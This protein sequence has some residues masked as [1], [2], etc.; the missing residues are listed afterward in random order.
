ML[1]TIDIGNT[2]IVMGLFDGKELINSW[3]LRTIQ[4]RTVDEFEVLLSQRWSVSG[5][6]ASQINEI[7]I[8][9]VVPPILKSLTTALKRMCHIE[10]LIVGPGVKTGISILLDNPKEVGA[11]RVVN[12]VAAHNRFKSGIIVV[13]FGTATTFDCISPKAEYLGGAIAPGI[14]ISTQALIKN[15]AQLPDVEI[16]KP[17]SVV[18]KNTVDGLKSGFF[19]G[20]I[21]LVDGL[22][23]RLQNELDFPCHVIATGGIA[24]LIAGDSRTIQEVDSLL[25]LKGLRL[26]HELNT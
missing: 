11:D 26:I 18:G 5:F 15:T 19:Y 4:D 7:V 10:P 21:G 16:L 13:D 17:N 25:T 1:L 24:A 23:E 2:N 20:Y 12:A 3:R 8:A 22:V 14:R 9:C 6:E